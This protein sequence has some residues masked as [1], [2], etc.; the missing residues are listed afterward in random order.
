MQRILLA[1]WLIDAGTFARRHMVLSRWLWPH[2]A[3]GLAVN[4]ALVSPA[5]PLEGEFEQP[6]KGPFSG[7]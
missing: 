3:G 4:F 6:D 5:C 2:P 7:N 1:P